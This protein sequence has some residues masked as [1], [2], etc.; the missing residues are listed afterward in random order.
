[1]S[2]FGGAVR[3]RRQRAVWMRHPRL[4]PTEEDRPQFY[5]DFASVLLALVGALI[6][7]YL[8]L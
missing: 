3:P 6:N 7:F 4:F 1:M 5:R 8:G 2:P